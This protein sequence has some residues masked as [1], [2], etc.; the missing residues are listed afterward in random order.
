[1]ATSVKPKAG[2]GAHTSDRIQVNFLLSGNSR[3][4][5]LCRDARRLT[6]HEDWVNLLQV[7]LIEVSNDH[8]GVSELKGIITRESYSLPVNFKVRILL[9]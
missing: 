5:D 4:H 9:W 3:S 6:Q 2:H 1:M 7:G 8:M